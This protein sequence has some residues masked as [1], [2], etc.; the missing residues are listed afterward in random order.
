VERGAELFQ[1]EKA[2]LLMSASMPPYLTAATGIDALSHQLSSQYGMPHG[3]AMGKSVQGL[4]RM[5]AARKAPAAVRQ[6]Q[7]SL[8]LPTTLKEY[9][10]DPE[11]LPV[12]AKL[13]LEDVDIP[14]NPRSLTLEQTE[15]IFA[16]AYEG[17][18]G[19]E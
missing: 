6:L 15:T 9:G 10:I 8:G 13:A 4:S 3:V 16:K 2:D 11:L 19:Q 12:C 5:D 1:K 18:F 17:D 14:A 7:K